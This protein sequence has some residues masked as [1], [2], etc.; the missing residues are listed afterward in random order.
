VLENDFGA[1]HVGFYGVHRLF[2][3]QFD[4]DG[5]GEVKH[6]VAAVDQFGEQRLVVDG[7]DEVFEPRSALQVPDVVDRSGRQ[8][9]EDEDFVT[10]FQ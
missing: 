2:D 9:I 5:R 6:H 7:V 4:T 1:V 8:I 10:L 3:D